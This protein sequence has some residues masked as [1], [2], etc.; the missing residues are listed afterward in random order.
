MASGQYDLTH[1]RALARALQDQSFRDSVHQ[2][3]LAKAMKDRG[4]K[5]SGVPQKLRTALNGL[6]RDELE[7]FAK[8]QKALKGS[9]LSNTLIAQMV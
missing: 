1:V 3:G 5:S 9:G 6:S 2:G 8:M 7:G 4:I